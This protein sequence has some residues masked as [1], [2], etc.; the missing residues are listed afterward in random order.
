VAQVPP[1]HYRW[2]TPVD[3]SLLGYVVG[4]RV[5]VL[6]NNG[7]REGVFNFHLPDGGWRPVGSRDR[8]DHQAGVE[9]ELPR[10]QGGARE[11]VV[12]ARSFLIWV[13]DDPADA[14]VPARGSP[15]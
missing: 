15:P 3:P 8:V 11:V 4:G 5:L 13:L 9:D 10:L 14:F 1:K 6:A 12:P 2:I 7:D